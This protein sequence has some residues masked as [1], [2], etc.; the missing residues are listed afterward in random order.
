ML[1]ISLS[2]LQWDN[3][4]NTHYVV[5]I[6]IKN[7]TVIS[8]QVFLQRVELM[9]LVHERGSGLPSLPSRRWLCADKSAVF[10]LMADRG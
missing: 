8:L 10:P 2:P 6:G 4:T 9:V 3:Q 5:N 1:G 7:T